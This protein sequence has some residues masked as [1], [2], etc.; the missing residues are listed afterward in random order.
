[1][2]FHPLLVENSI[3]ISFPTIRDNRHHRAFSQFLSQFADGCKYYAAG[4]SSDQNRLGA[5]EIS[6]GIERFLITNFESFINQIIGNIAA[7]G[8]IAWIARARLK[9]WAFLTP[10][11]Y[12]SDGFHTNNLNFRIIT[13]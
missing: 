13:F 10:K 7:N 11:N 8:Y 6:G 2:F 3:K 12:R 5:G 9:I 1:M 4:R